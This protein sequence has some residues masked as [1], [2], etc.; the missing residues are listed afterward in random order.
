M[1]ERG[2]GA[3]PEP[4]AAPARAPALPAPPLG[5]PR[6][7]Q[8]APPPAPR[9]PRPAA[10]LGRL[11]QGRGRGMRERP[12]VHPRRRLAGR[13]FRALDHGDPAG[14][15]GGGDCRPGVAAG[16]FPTPQARE[17]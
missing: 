13:L 4:R 15:P 5:V 9:R 12:R 17:S 11:G 16:R 2:R 1:R 6:R 10:A 8:A 3:R 7:P 14:R